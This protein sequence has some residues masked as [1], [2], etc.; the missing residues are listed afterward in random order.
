[1]IKRQYRV[2]FVTPAFLRGAAE[3]PSADQTGAEWRESSIRG[4][5]RWWFRAVAWVRHGN[6]ALVRAAE[7]GV[8]GST[9]RQSA[10]AIRCDHLNVQGSVS[11]DLD[12][13]F[14]QRG[15]GREAINGP[16]YLGFGP[17][18]A[19]RPYI[20][21]GTRTAF[22]VVQRDDGEDDL[23]QLA[24]RAWSCL[25]GI[26]A[27]SRRGYGSLEISG[28]ERDGNG[29]PGDSNAQNVARLLDEIEALARDRKPAEHPAIGGQRLAGEQDWPRFEALLRP[30]TAF[31]PLSRVLVWRNPQ[32]TWEGALQV[33]GEALIRFRRRYGIAGRDYEWA[34]R[35][36]TEAHIPDRVGFGLPIPFSRNTIVQAARH[37]RRGSPLLIHIG[38]TPGQHGDVARYCPVLTYLPA[39][40]L[41]EGET[42]GYRHPPR[43]NVDHCE[44]VGWIQYKLVQDFLDDLVD[45]ST[46]TEITP[47]GGTR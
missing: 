2:E 3:K 43:K 35:P 21:P 18:Q 6:E 23:L 32:G 12:F 16:A 45:N 5:L 29:Q 13:A 46:V 47:S 4:Q 33:A 1:M 24:I 40:F 26:G 8:F 9:R 39:K 27:R 41:P 37:D 38:K 44:S 34:Y 28:P 30:I 25:G 11:K 20:T 31:S 14:P 10:I 7:E 17:V 19:E 15:Q 42:V 36:G 22:T